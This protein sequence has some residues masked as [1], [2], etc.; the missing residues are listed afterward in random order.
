L[1]NK[2]YKNINFDEIKND[3]NSIYIPKCIKDLENINNLNE[4][5]NS[6]LNNADIETFCS[7]TSSSISISTTTTTTVPK[8]NTNSYTRKIIGA[9]IGS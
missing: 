9:V 3:E 5:L 8:T 6:C 4:K 7:T 2:F 1:H